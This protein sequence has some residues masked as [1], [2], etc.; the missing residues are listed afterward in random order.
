MQLFDWNSCSAWQ[1]DDFGLWI[2][3]IQKYK[4][5]L[6]IKWYKSQ[7]THKTGC[8]ILCRNNI[9]KTTGWIGRYIMSQTAVSMQSQLMPVRPYPWSWRNKIRREHYRFKYNVSCISHKYVF[10]WRDDS[11]TSFASWP[12]CGTWNALQSV[13]PGGDRGVPNMLILLPIFEFSSTPVS[14]VLYSDY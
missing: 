6:A 8:H 13:T 7:V 9:I 5:C 3:L 1:S 14:T 12:N 4:W 10:K 11:K 2:Q